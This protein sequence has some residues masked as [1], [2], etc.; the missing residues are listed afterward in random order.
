MLLYSAL[1][2]FSFVNGKPA[3]IQS[4]V[5]RF[6]GLVTIPPRWLTP[7]IRLD[8]E[9]FTK[10]NEVEVDRQSYTMPGYL[11]LSNE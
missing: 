1:P 11:V 4:T 3:S 8:L 9:N 10:G 6:L 5:R 2:E 7:E